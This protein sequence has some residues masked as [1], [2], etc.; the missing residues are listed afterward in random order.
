MTSQLRL[1]RFNLISL[2]IDYDTGFA[3]FERVEYLEEGGAEENY[4][5]R[6]VYEILNEG[7]EA[8]EDENED[9]YAILLSINCIPAKNDEWE[10]ATTLFKRVDITLQGVFGLDAYTEVDPETLS[11]LLQFNAPAI[12]HGI[13]RGIVASATGSCLEGPFLIPVVN[14]RRISDVERELAEKRGMADSET[15]DTQQPVDPQP[16]IGSE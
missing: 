2:A 5:V 12:L 9:R 3:D 10:G 4:E 8:D 13:A 11:Q 7:F 6:A 14:Y 16:G 15:S 1:D